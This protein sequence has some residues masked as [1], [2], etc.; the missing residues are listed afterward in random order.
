MQSLEILVKAR[1]KPKKEELHITNNKYDM[2]E[3]AAWE[4]IGN[5]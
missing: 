1:E 2:G 3:S 4:K 5:R